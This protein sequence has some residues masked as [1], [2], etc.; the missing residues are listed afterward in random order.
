MKNLIRC[1]IICF[2]AN[3]VNGQD[4]LQNKIYDKNIKTV[5]MYLDND[6][7]SLPIWDLGSSKKLNLNFDDLSNEY[8]DFYY[9]IIHCNSDWTQSNLDQGEYIDGF[10]EN[11]ISEYQTSFNTTVNYTHYRLELP[12]DYIQLNKSGNYIVKVYESD[13]PDVIVFT[14]RFM[15]IERKTDVKAVVSNMNQSSYFSNNQELE[16]NVDYFENEFYDLDQKIEL[17]ILKNRNWET[18]G[19]IG[20]IFYALS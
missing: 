3:S 19:N 16:V 1:I 9:T 6:D 20:K 5:L 17:Q 14:K 2:V 10:Y 12:N 15:I 18:D 13:Y 8:K 4:V 11:A 7:M